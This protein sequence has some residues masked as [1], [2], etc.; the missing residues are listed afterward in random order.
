MSLATRV[1]TAVV[2]VGA[3]GVLVAGV[4][5]PAALAAD[6][7][8]V[9]AAQPGAARVGLG[10][11]PTSLVCPPAPRLQ[12]E[13]DGD[14]GGTDEDFQAAGSTE[15]TTTVRADGAD[16]TAVVGRTL[17][18][19]DLAAQDLVG[20]GAGLIAVGSGS[21]QPVVVEAAPDAPVAGLQ[22]TRTDDGDLAGLAASSCTTPTET[23]WLVGG[24][25]E[26]GRSGRIVLSNPSA[27][28]ASVDLTVLTPEGPVAPAAGQDLAVGAGTSR[29]VL[30]EA[31]LP[32]TTALAVG[33]TARGAAVA[34]QL[35]DTYVSGV[36]AQGV[37]HVAATSPATA[38]TVPGVLAAA[39]TTTLR[40]A[41][42]GPEPAA[43]GWQVLGDDGALVL[44]A[45][46]VTTVPPGAV[47]DLP[48]DLTGPDGEPAAGPVALQVSADQPV[49]GAVQVRLGRDDGLSEIAW[50]AP[51]PALDDEALTLVGPEGV[52]SFVSLAAG[53]AAE[54]RLQRLDAAG[55]LV[56]DEVAVVLE[57]GTTRTIEVDDDAVAVRLVVVSGTVHAALALTG[58]PDG[59]GG[60]FFSVVPVQVPP[61]T[62]D[63]V[64]VG[65]LPEDVLRAPTS[66]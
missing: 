55:E 9:A 10:D 32:P 52:R 61:A 46:A 24:A 63:E 34:G 21:E 7:G 3:T 43:V 45:E 25:V 8:L 14:A 22:V 4:L 48:L 41:N 26:A 38:F 39:R 40:L 12:A 64:T 66:P 28:V 5:D 33:V 42:P 2:A 51:A 27:T 17:P 37:E 57:P 20:E 50:A 49:L 31:L 1:L 6:A 47:V 54:V 23:A 11:L 19:Q 44:A 29:E 35:V 18:P 53:E 62:T 15:Q 58:G 30:L 16:A 13:V 36:R 59:E 56:D 60:T 65:P